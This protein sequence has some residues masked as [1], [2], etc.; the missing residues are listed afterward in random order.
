M[1]ASKAPSVVCPWRI[2]PSFKTR[3]TRSP[4]EF[5][6]PDPV[7]GV[8]E[9]LNVGTEHDDVRQTDT[10]VVA[11]TAQPEV[12]DQLLHNPVAAAEIEHS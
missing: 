3:I 4:R 6:R 5:L 9:V 8:V 12:Q 2:T 7:H 10:E 11:E 1:M